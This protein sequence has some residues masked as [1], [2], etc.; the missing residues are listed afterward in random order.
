MSEFQ[1]WVTPLH[2]STTEPLS[3]GGWIEY[4]D[5]PPTIEVMGSLLYTLFQERWAEVQLGHV[6][7]GSVLELEFTQPPKIC[8][9]YDGYLTVVTEA[10]HLHLCVE[11]H[12][13][14]PLQKTPPDLQKQRLVSR[15]SLYRRF[16]Q[17]GQPRSWGIQFWNGSGEQMMTLFLPNPFV[18]AD[19]DLLPEGKPQLEKLGLYEEL[20][21]IYILGHR[22]IPF[23]DNPLKRPYLSV[24][25]SGR[26]LPSR[27][28]QPVYDAL[29]DAVQTSGLAVEVMTSGC[30]EVCKLGPVVFSS[31]ESTWYT[32][33][34]PDVARQIVQLDLIEGHKVTDH[35]YP[36]IG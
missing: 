26:C 21:Q 24:C 27:Q 2:R 33:V 20:R 34:T 28:W 7:E 12:Q 6:V 30:L 1:P 18:G 17:E 11:V 5:F 4:E 19:E 16:N 23:S 14:G 22:P 29:V 25:R 9:I 3:Q 36:P 15:G 10:W 31:Q 8:L 32:R 35:L 13:G